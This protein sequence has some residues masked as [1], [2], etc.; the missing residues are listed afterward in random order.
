MRGMVVRRRRSVDPV[1][2]VFQ[3]AP[4]PISN[5]ARTARVF[6]SIGFL[7]S[8]G[9][10]CA[11]ETER[12]RQ[13][14]CGRSASV[15]R[16]YQRLR[17]QIAGPSRLLY[18]PLTSRCHPLVTPDFTREQRD[19][20]L[21]ILR[22]S[23]EVCGSFLITCRRGQERLAIAGEI[24]QGDRAV[25]I[26]FFLSASGSQSRKGQAVITCSVTPRRAP[27]ALRR[28]REPNRWSHPWRGRRFERHSASEL[29][30]RSPACRRCR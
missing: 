26:V 28:R 14:W 7:D 10:G 11:H 15:H 20:E 21:T 16:A 25:L 1:L 24:A 9:A 3:Q 5:L 13:A 17:A 19:E 29:A 6:A 30:R 2:C 27:A 12:A 22:S 23:V 4:R 18:V 8:T